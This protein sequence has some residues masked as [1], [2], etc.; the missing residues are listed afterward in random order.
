MPGSNA[1]SDGGNA[2]K[3]ITG[4]SFN[5]APGKA[6]TVF[7]VAGIRKPEF[8]GAETIDEFAATTRKS[9]EVNL[10]KTDGTPVRERIVIEAL[11][12]VELAERVQKSDTLKHQI[13]QQEF[14]ARFMNEINANPGFRAGMQEIIGDPQRKAQL[15]NALKEMRTLLGESRPPVLNFLLNP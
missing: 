14:L 10:R 8:F 11:E 2:A 13:R 6:L 4:S 15:L 5:I 1:K 9:Y 12:D 3:H 7:P